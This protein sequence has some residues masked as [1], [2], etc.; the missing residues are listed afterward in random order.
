MRYLGVGQPE[1][2]NDSLAYLQVLQYQRG[3]YSRR[4]PRGKEKILI[5]AGTTPSFH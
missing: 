1:M 2:L 5:A 3:K 4:E